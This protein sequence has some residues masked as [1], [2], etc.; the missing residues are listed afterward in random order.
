MDENTNRKL[1][2][3]GCCGMD[4]S[5]YDRKIRYFCALVRTFFVHLTIV[6][7]VEVPELSGCIANGNTP[8]EALA[9]VEEK[10]KIW[11]EIVAELGWK[12]PRSNQRSYNITA[13]GRFCHD[14]SVYDI[15]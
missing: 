2:Y 4:F 14:V 1:A 8:A 7:L 13:K 12:I 3:F 6:S 9:H 5:S 10:I 11:L 15:E